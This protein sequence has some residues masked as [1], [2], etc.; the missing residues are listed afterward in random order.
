MDVETCWKWFNEVFVPEVKRR[1]GRPVLLLMD[2]APGHFDAFE[3]NNIRE[4]S[5]FQTVLAGNSLVIWES[6]S[7]SR[8]DTNIY[9]SRIS[10]LLRA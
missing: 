2:N 1:T 6:S 7:L 3:R 9:I 10:R 8:N 4:I 5:F